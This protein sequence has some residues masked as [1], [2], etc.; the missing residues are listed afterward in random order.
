MFVNNVSLGLY[1][2]AVQRPG[3]REAKL[4]TLLDTV[5]S[6]LGPGAKAPNLRWQSPHGQ[7]SA[8]AILISN[9][10][11]R[12]GRVLGAGTR[13]RLDQGVL[14]ISVL[15]PIETNGRGPGTRILALQQ[16]TARGFDVRADGA[17]NAGI[18]GEAAVLGPTL[19]FRALPNSLRVR[20]APGHPG[21][22]PSA[23]EP[24]GLWQTVRALVDLALHGERGHR[25]RS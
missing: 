15:V 3:Y 1:A 4:H 18:D 22:S 16:W 14:G 9:N 25:T 20:I 19:H 23:V 12:L 10:A 5:P 21:A 7:Q 2:D 24:E 6:V 17:T 8:V 11:Y 13:P